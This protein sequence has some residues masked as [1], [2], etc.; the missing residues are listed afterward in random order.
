M[1]TELR[2]D[3]E[4]HFKSLIE[5]PNSFAQPSAPSTLSFHAQSDSPRGVPDGTWVEAG[6]KQIASVS[7]LGIALDANVGPYGT[8]DNAK[9]LDVRRFSFTVAFCQCLNR[10]R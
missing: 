10:L 2:P 3:I 7:I 4:K 6:S 8:A 1:S 9:S 5:Q